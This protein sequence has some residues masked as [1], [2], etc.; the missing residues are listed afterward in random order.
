MAPVRISLLTATVASLALAAAGLSAQ[1]PA[2]TTAPGTNVSSGT[3]SVTLHASSRTALQYHGVTFQARASNGDV[4]LYAFTYGDGSVQ[5][6]YQPVALHGYQKPGT[7]RARVGVL[8]ASG[9]V[10]VSTPVTIHVV[11]GVPPVVRIDTPGP[12]QRLRLGHAGLSFKGSATDAN[13]VRKVQIAV[14]LLSSA[15]HFNTGG[16]C[17]WYDGSTWLVLAPCASPHYFT[18]PYAHGHWSFHMSGKARIPAGTYEIQVRAI[19]RAGNISHYYATSLR[20][21]LPFRIAR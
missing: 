18:V 3:L 21:I 6:S 20:T 7:Y 4:T 8:D 11:D 14:Q 12:G 1:A 17:I 16:A 2:A 13:G 5:Y 19:D 15:R 9:Q 10:A